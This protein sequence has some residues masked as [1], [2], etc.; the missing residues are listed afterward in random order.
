MLFRSVVRR[1]LGGFSRVILTEPLSYPDFVSVMNR[2]LFIVSD[3]GGIQERQIKP[4]SFEMTFNVLVEDYDHK[5][6]EGEAYTR[7]VDPY[8]TVRDNGSG[9]LVDGNGTHFGNIDYATGTVKFKPD[10][11]TRI[12]KPKI[13]RAHV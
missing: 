1:E 7:Q 2:S 6:Q 9:G 11:T 4:R 12:P 3:S 5:V 8:V 13:G 10:Y